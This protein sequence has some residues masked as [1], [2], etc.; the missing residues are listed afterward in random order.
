MGGDA[1][2][3]G[4]ATVIAAAPFSG[5]AEVVGPREVLVAVFSVALVLLAAVVPAVAAALG[6]VPVLAGVVS[7]ISEDSP[8]TF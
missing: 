3:L 5:C 8:V 2:A 6:A 1:A 7:I 4:A